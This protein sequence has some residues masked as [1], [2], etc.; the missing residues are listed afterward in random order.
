MKLFYKKIFDMFVE[1]D[2]NRSRFDKNARMNLA[3]CVKLGEGVNDCVFVLVKKAEALKSGIAGN[4]E[5]IPN[6]ATNDKAGNL[7]A[8]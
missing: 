8:F 3:L 5:I 2:I 1:R 7:N 4:F 6:Y